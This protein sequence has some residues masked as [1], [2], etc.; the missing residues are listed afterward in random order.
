M[1]ARTAKGKQLEILKT[2]QDDRIVT[3]NYHL[4][5]EKD[6]NAIPD[7]VAFFDLYAAGLLERLHLDKDLRAFGQRVVISEKGR[8]HLASLKKD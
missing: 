4:H 2:L 8:E 7:E 5:Y 3:A 1:K 6:V